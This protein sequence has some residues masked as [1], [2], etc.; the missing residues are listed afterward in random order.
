M[1][2]LPQLVAISIWRIAATSAFLAA[3]ERA[4]FLRH[5]TESK[6]LTLGAPHANDEQ[7]FDVLRSQRRRHLR[8]AA[9]KG[10]I[11]HWWR[12]VTACPVRQRQ[13]LLLA[14]MPLRSPIR[15]GRTQ[16]LLD[17]IRNESLFA[18]TS[19]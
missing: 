19:G 10:L 15:F 13:S 18:V 16:R 2:G 4:V 14:R 6:S 17:D 12:V 1:P 11:I 7:I 5:P 3:G 9:G 8:Q